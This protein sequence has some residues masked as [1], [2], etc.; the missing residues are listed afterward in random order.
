MGI[1]VKTYFYCKKVCLASVI[2]KSKL[3]RN[4][5]HFLTLIN[6]KVV[7]FYIKVRSIAIL[8]NF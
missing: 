2:K 4:F 1:L 7:I 8:P 6:R 5:E 3:P